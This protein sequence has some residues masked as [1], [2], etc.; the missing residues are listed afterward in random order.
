MK[1]PSGG[2]VV[3]VNNEA[4]GAA[5]LARNRQGDAELRVRPQAVR[6]TA[7]WPSSSS[8]WA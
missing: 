5:G 4:G 6:G 8:T 1:Q 2:C 3:A 7:K